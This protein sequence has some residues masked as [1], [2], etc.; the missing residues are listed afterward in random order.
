MSAPTCIT[1]ETTKQRGGVADE[2]DRLAAENA[3]LRAHL[4]EN[5]RG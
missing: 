1:T 5:S 2:R 4:K 3:Q